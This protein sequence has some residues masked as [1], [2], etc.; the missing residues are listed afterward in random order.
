MAHWILFGVI[1]GA[2]SRLFI[3]KYMHNLAKQLAPT[4]EL[5]QKVIEFEN[6]EVTFTGELMVAV[7]TVAIW[8]LLLL[9][10]VMLFLSYPGAKK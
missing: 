3:S 6:R 7:T 5:K 8:P 10:D 9:S 1:Y 2:A 4:P